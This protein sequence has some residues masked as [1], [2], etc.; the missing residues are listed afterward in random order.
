MSNTTPSLKPAEAIERWYVVDASKTVLG[1]LATRVATVLRGKDLATFTPH[2]PGKTHVIIINAAKLKVTGQKLDQKT[3]YRHS[4]RPGS[5]RSRTLAE[6]LE[7][8]PRMPVER[9]VAGMLPDNRL[10]SI[11]L[12]HLHV[13]AG[14]DHDHQAQQPKELPL[15]D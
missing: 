13:Y 15:N 11:W 4:G 1:R 7:R 10:R 14:A 9:A 8:D 12:N 3:Y 5:L 6:Q 2:V